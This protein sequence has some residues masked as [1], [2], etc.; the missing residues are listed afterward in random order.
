MITEKVKKE[1]KEFFGY[2]IESENPLVLKGE[3]SDE[4]LVGLL[5]ELALKEALEAINE[6]NEEPIKLDDLTDMDDDSMLLVTGNFNY[7][8]EFDLSEWTTMTVGEFKELVEKLKGQEDEFEW[9]FGTNEQ[10]IFENGEDLLSQLSF[11]K[12]TDEQSD[13]LD[14]LFDGSFDGGSGVFDRIWE[15]G[16]DEDEDEDEDDDNER[17]IFDKSDLKQIELLKTFG[18]EVGVHDEKDFMLSFTSPQG[19]VSIGGF[20]NLFELSN[21]LK[22]NK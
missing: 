20:S 12:I 17:S 1:L 8:D 10:L 2:E 9:Y 14:K 6:E 3:D 4:R 16:D 7:A 22:K 5:A 15:L 13:V 19:E 21:Y 18:W 11:E